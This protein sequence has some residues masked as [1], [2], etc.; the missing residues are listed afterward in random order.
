MKLRDAM[1]RACVV[2]NIQNTMSLLGIG[3]EVSAIRKK[4]GLLK[5]R[6]SRRKRDESAPHPSG[7]RCIEATRE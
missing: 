6:K 1:V 2:H 3:K 5:K 4:E 7:H